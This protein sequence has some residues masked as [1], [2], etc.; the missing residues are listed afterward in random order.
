[1]IKCDKC[2]NDKAILLTRQNPK[3][4]AGIFHC[5]KCTGENITNSDSDLVTAI[6]GSDD[7]KNQ[8]E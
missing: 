7:W 3:G 1:M 4:Q 6:I 2:G 5:E 8:D